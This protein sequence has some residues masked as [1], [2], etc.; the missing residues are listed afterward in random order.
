MYSSPTGSG[1]T[2]A[3]VVPIQECLH[4]YATSKK[5]RA[6]VI[7]PTQNL[8]EQVHDVFCKFEQ[9][10]GVRAGLAH[11]AVHATKELNKLRHK[12]TGAWLVDVVVGTPGRL[13]F[14][15][16]SS[17]GFGLEHLQFLVL[18]EVDKLLLEQ[19]IDSTRTLMQS[20]FDKYG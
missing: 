19:S 17:A 11:G 13:L 8:A 10:T 14:H 20:Y 16:Q 1:K 7:V 15:I 9:F 3:Y 6:L 4:M 12:Q 2:L 5:L 18:D